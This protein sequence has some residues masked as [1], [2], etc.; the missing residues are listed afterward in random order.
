MDNDLL[1][2]NPGF[3]N[4]AGVASERQFSLNAGPPLPVEAAKRHGHSGSALILWRRSRS[5][6]TIP[7]R[8]KVSLQPNQRNSIASFPVIDSKPKEYEISEIQIAT[9][10]GV[11]C[12]VESPTQYA[13]P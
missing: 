12:A 5:S 1:K 6:S 3:A 7:A 11:V 13:T 10:R 8:I 2:Q 9:E 4:F